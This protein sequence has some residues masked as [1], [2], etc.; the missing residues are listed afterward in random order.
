M[1]IAHWRKNWCHLGVN[2]SD[3]MGL[4][5]LNPTDKQSLIKK[6]SDRRNNTLSGI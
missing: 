1:N 3:G 4:G 6:N 2:L 5:E